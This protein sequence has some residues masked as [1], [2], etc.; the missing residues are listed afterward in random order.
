MRTN[1]DSCFF[2]SATFPLLKR[3]MVPRLW[4]LALRLACSAQV[5]GR[6]ARWQKLRW[7]SWRLSREWAKIWIVNCVA[8]DDY[9]PFKKAVEQFQQLDKVKEWTPMGD[10]KADE[11]A[12]CCVYNWK[13]QHYG[14]NDS[15]GWGSPCQSCRP[16][17]GW[18]ALIYHIMNN[19]IKKCVKTHRVLFR[20]SSS[21]PRAC[22][23]VRS[24]AYR[25]HKQD[26][27]HKARKVWNAWH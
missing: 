6:S 2:L 14:P 1:V 9:D 5:R 10:G 15:C 19:K 18:S 22:A 17:D 11:S 4:T 26:E 24:C 7:F 8:P 12:S 23:R 21:P 20:Y 16:Y 13:R 3:Q 25:E 27:I